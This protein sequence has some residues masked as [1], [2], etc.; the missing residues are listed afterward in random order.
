MKKL[1]VLIILLFVAACTLNAAEILVWNFNPENYDV[2]TDPEAGQQINCGYWLKEC[3]TNNGYTFTYH[4]NIQL[5]SDIS[6]YD[7]I[8]GTVGYHEC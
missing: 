4:D 7:V 1:S 6:S 3:L 2:Y 5:P 8:V